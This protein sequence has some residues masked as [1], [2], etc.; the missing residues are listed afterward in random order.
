MSEQNRYRIEHDYKTEKG[1]SGW[2]SWP[3]AWSG[4]TW[5]SVISKRLK[6]IEGIVGSSKVTVVSEIPSEDGRSGIIE[7]QLERPGW[8]VEVNQPDWWEEVKIK[9][10]LI[11]D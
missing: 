8:W 5:Q 1:W 10:T 9:A 11:E 6:D 3:V 7:T 2:V 4:D